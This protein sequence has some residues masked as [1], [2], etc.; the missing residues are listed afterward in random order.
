MPRSIDGHGFV[1]ASSPPP[2]STVSPRSLRISALI[3]GN[4]F[5]ADPGLSVVIP[6]SAVIMIA[7]VSV[8]H[9]VSTTGQRSPPM[10]RWYQTQASGLIGSPTDPSRRS[11]DRLWRSGHSVP[12][13]MNERIAV[14]AV[15][16]IVA[17][18]V[19]TI[20]HHRSL[21]GKS[22]VPSYITPVV[23]FASGP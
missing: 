16:R 5:V 3:P 11:D 13:R 10:N 17:V 23:W 1:I 8:C 15:Y 6:G 20:D 22:G 9:H 2:T 21:S 14:G 18:Y 7:P 4:G 12:H 19:S